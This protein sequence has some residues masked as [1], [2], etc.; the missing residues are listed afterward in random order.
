[1]VEK[2]LYN[3]FPPVKTKK[4]WNDISSYAQMESETLYDTQER[5]KD[6][7]KRCPHHGLPIWLQVQ[8]FY[9]EL[10]NATRQMIDVIVKG[11]LNSKTLEVAQDLI[12]EM[13]I[14]SYQWYFSQAKPSKQL[15]FILWIPL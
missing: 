6:L 14:N 3:Y 10:N 13:V 12:E 9:N 1:M 8:I 15:K 5:V 2:F 11:P 7:L 4:V